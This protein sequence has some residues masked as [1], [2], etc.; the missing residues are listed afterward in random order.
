MRVRSAFVIQRDVI[1]AIFIREIS[2]RFGNNY[3]FGNVWL[4]LEPLV[5][6]SVFITIFGF[7]NIQTL[8]NVAPPVFVII[9]Y[10]PFRMIWSST[11][12]KNMGAAGARGLFGFRQIRLFDVFLAYSLIEGGIFLTVE[13]ILVIAL[14]W[15]GFDSIP[16]DPL[17]FIGYASTVWLF[18]I[19]FGILA[20]VLSRIAKEVEK[21]INIMTLPLLLM[22]AVIY[23]ITAV[24]KN[25]LNFFSYNPLAHA[26][27]LF[28]EAWITG[29]ESPIAD[30]EYLLTW[31]IILMAISVSSYRLN[32][33]WVMTR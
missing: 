30:Y 2:S 4:L 23:P 27:E 11:M 1:F 25:Y 16:A 14:M 10:V 18:A 29:Y 12:K 32:W 17:L 9:T 22:S 31:T 8:G 19:S 6:M 13:T 3:A 28:R 7:R 5:L 20:C 33:R 26:S 24:P 21:M 15:F